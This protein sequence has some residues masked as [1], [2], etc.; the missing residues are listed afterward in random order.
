MSDPLFV[1]KNKRMQIF[2]GKHYIFDGIRKKYVRLTPEEGARQYFVGYLTNV[3]H[4]PKN[5]IRIERTI[6]GDLQQHRPD[7]VVYDRQ[8][9]PFLVAECKAPHIALTSHMHNQLARYNRL[10]LAPLL[11]IT[12]GKEYG[13][14]AANYTHG[15]Q[16]RKLEKIPCFTANIAAFWDKL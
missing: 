7:L 5:L 12:N 16:A 1:E 15:F 10:L 9:R 13:C 8:G 3:L 4:Y 6:A 2:H 14:W 11:V